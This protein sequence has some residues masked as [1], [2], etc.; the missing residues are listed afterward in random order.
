MRIDYVRRRLVLPGLA[1][2]LA[3]VIL[4][5]VILALAFGAAARPAAAQE[6]NCSVRVDYSKLSGNSFGFLADLEHLV[7]EYI[8]QHAW[9]E[10]RFRDEERIDC[11]IQI[12]FEQS[13]SLTSFQ[14]NLI[15][16]S[17][18]P[19]YNTGVSTTVVQFI[20][21][22][23]QFNFAAGTPLN[24]NLDQYDPLT[25]VL[26]FYAYMMLGY[27]YDTFSERGGTRYFET[28]RRIAE[29]A[30]GQNA[31]GWSQIGDDRGRFDLVSQILDQRWQPLRL[32]YFSY[33]LRGLDRFVTDTETARTTVM[34]VLASIDELSDTINRM[35]VLDVFFSAKY[36]ELAA[37]FQGSEF[38]SQAYDLLSTLDPSHMSE[39]NKLVQ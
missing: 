31:P 7:T 38:S 9:T 20:D 30:Q 4:A 6:F 8:N 34:E 27:D 22:N 10:D 35:F 32:A 28:A 23:W 15:V 36:Q 3:P 21:S 39:Y 19:I 24:F 29:R 5:P 33:H 26:D 17:R 11:T 14:A 18:R 25:S 13:I 12:N 2:L 1:R 16:A 37:I